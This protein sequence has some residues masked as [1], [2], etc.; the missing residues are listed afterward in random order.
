MSDVFDFEELLAPKKLTKEDKDTAADK[1]WIDFWANHEKIV[2]SS[3][4]YVGGI[5][6]TMRDHSVSI[7]AWPQKPLEPL[8]TSICLSDKE[9]VEIVY[10]RFVKGLK[11]YNV[12]IFNHTDEMKEAIKKCSTE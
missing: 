10:K 5:L 1:N 12:V 4:F 8:M 9:F 6:V 3:C 2:L 7:H 11:E